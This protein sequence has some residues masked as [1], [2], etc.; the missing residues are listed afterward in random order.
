MCRVELQIKE[1]W[2]ARQTGEPQRKTRNR[3]YPRGVNPATYDHW[4]LWNN[5]RCYICGERCPTERNLAKDHQHVTD[6][7]RGLLCLPCNTTLGVA[8][9][10]TELLHACATFL[11]AYLDPYIIVCADHGRHGCRRGRGS[12]VGVPCL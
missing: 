2:E 6:R 4:S 3:Q 8:Q 12:T 1:D 10:D 9:E 11:H 5:H 7:N